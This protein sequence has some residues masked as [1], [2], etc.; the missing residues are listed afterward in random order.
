MVLAR[1]LVPAVAL[2]SLAVAAPAQ[3]THAVR[4]GDNLWDLAA[5]YLADPFRWPEIHRLNAGIVED[6]HWIYPGEVLRLPGRGGAPAGAVAAAVRARGAGGEESFDAPSLFDQDRSRGAMGPGLSFDAAARGSVVSFSD[7]Y[8]AGFLA[9]EA[10]LAP[11]GWTVRHFGENP[12]DLDLP[13]AVRLHDRVLLDLGGASAA[14]GDVWQAIQWDRTVGTHGRIV[15]SVAVLRLTDVGADTARARVTHLFGP[16]EEGDPVIPAEPYVPQPGVLPEPV[17]D[18]LAARLI[19]FEVEQPLI[20]PGDAVFLDVGAEAGVRL[21]DEFAVFGGAVREGSGGRLDDAL[22]TVRVVRVRPT[23]S[24]AMV[25]SLRE[26]GA[27]P[28]A[29][30]RMVRRMPPRGE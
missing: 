14:P 21:G 8:R 22:C 12:L 13:P 19:G 11:L 26:A 10:E 30:A 15:R 24:T 29:A 9:R 4:R 5:R 16:F 1:A 17:E 6:P 2:G 7:F 25:V 23:T 3:E 20:S 28:G 27:E 18:G